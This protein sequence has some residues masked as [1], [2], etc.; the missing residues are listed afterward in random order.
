MIRLLERAAAAVPDQPAVI[1]TEATT[2]YAGLLAAARATGAALQARGIDRFALVEPDAGRVLTLLAGA[3]LVGTEPCQYQPDIDAGQ[4]REQAAAL[5]HTLVVSRRTD[6]AGDGLV[7]LDPAELTATGPAT[8]AEEQPI[9]IRTT[10]TTGLPKAARHDWSV[11]ARTTRSATPRPGQ[12]WLL[13][14][15]PQQFAGIQVLQHVL[16]IQ[17][18]L[19][20]PF[21]RQPRDGL[22]ALLDPRPDRRP[23]CVSA[24]PTYWRFLLA[25]ARGRGVALPPLAQVTLGGEASSPDLLEELRTAFPD[26]RIS[27]VYA[28]TEFG[29]IA[30]VGDGRP[31]LSVASLWSP[32]NPEGLLRVVDGQLWVRAGTGMSGYAGDRSDTP[33]EEDGWVPTGDLAEVVEDRVLFRGRDSEVINVGGVKVHPLPVEERISALPGVSMARVFGRPN[34]LT[35]AIVATEVVPVGELAATDAEALKREVRAAV[36]DLPPAWRPRSIALVEELAT[37][38]TK[39]LRGMAAAES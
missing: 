28:S 37:K 26:A 5:G 18:T 8:P 19:V 33:V 35:G 9:L 12:R 34:R 21:P 3:A 7:V 10:G 38:G 23:D 17:G 22:D 15:G 6:L 16:A 1:T 39:T 32:E 2:T 30:S 29:S 13:A 24:T 11:L 4:F 25:E 14:Y 31:G 27:Q 20:A 36:A